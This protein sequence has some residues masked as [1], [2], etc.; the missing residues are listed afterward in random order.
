MC[1]DEFPLDASLG[2]HFFHNMIS[3]NVG[4]FSVKHNSL[5]DYINWDVFSQ[6]EV[7]TETK[8]FRHVRFKN[9]VNVFMD[10]KKRVSLIYFGTEK[11]SKG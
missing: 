4:Y 5:I 2:S 8:Y 11:N 7:V 1:L 6:Q 9:P 10:G 3:M